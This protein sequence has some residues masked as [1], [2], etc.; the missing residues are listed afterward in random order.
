MAYNDL[1]QVSYKKVYGV[2]N[3]AIVSNSRIHYYG[4]RSPD[5]ET[6]EVMQNLEG[7]VDEDTQEFLKKLG[8]SG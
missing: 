3:K 8:K 5:E 6:L 7:S 4:Y 1:L 2:I